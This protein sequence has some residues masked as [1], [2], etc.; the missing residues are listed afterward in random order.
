LG[1]EIRDAARLG[2]ASAFHRTHDT[3]VVASLGDLK[4]AIDHIPQREH[5]AEATPLAD[6][7][8]TIQDGHR[9]GPQL[10]GTSCRSC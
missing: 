1:E 7:L 8:R 5:A 6:E 10:L 2:N 3:G 9:R 4:A